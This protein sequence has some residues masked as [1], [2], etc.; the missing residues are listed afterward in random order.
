MLVTNVDMNRSMSTWNYNYSRLISSLLSTQKASF[1]LNS[2]H[3]HL[4]SCNIPFIKPTKIK[5]FLFMGM[6]GVKIDEAFTLQI[7]VDL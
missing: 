4:L 7:F 2:F 6:G 1:F 5:S 3:S